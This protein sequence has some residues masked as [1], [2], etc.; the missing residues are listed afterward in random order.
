MDIHDK[1]L[2]A[3]LPMRT[4]AANNAALPR[5]ERVTLKSQ[6]PCTA[7]AAHRFDNR[8]GV[9]TVAQQNFDDL[10]RQ[11]P[12]AE[13]AARFGV[14]EDTI[15]QAVRQA[16]SGL[17]GGMAV[18]SQQEEGAQKLVA[19]TQQHTPTP[20]GLKLEAIDEA[21]GEKIVG[22]VLGGK[23]DDVVRALGAR[24]G[25]SQIADLIPKLLPIIAPIIMQFIAGNLGKAGS[26]SSSSGSGGLTDL[27]GGLL[28][29][30]LGGGSQ[31][32]GGG[33]GD[34]LGGLLGGSR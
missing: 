6:A 11:V 1:P 16:G 29:G 31:S 33:L 20:G 26:A 18:N 8:E 30:Q 13:L 3:S 32:G 28:G 4:C 9:R 15:T 27:L 21:D 34:L 7:R 23:Q 19:A 5:G 22:H 24:S 25:G 17:L 10:L 2:P 12:V 14:D